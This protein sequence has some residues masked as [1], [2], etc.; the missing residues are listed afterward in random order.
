MGTF[1]VH[2]VCT[3]PVRPLRREAWL[4]QQSVAKVKGVL[5]A[6]LFHCALVGG[7]RFHSVDK[8]GQFGVFRTAL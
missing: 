5:N 8:G 7:A 1:S 3:P 2:Y 4:T 6:A